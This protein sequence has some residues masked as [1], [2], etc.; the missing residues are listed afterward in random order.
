MQRMQTL[1]L[2]WWRAAIGQKA[3]H[4]LQ[5][6]TRAMSSRLESVDTTLHE[7]L[8]S[9]DVQARAAAAISASQLAMRR[10]NVSIPPGNSTSLDH[11]AFAASL[12]ENY[13]ELDAAGNDR[14]KAAFSAARAATSFAFAVEG[15]A[16]EAVYEAIIAT[17]DLASVRAQVLAAVRTAC[18][19]GAKIEG[20]DPDK[21]E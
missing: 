2:S 1:Q 8:R 15:R 20:Q 7:M 3:V 14:S 6:S 21:A 17:E 4:N 11:H 16:E 18:S 9:A 10:C 5:K 19:S 12:D 13:F